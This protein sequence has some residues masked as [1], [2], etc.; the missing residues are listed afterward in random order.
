MELSKDINTV[1][2]TI[3]DILGLGKSYDI[4]ERKIIIDDTNISFFFIDGFVKDDSL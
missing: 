3:G 1:R 4:I 2:T